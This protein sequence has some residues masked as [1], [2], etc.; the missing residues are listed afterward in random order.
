MKSK[1]LA[2]PDQ[3]NYGNAYAL[4]YKLACEQL[5]RFDDIEQQCRKSGSKYQIIDSK[6]IIATQYLNQSYLITLPDIKISLEDGAEEVPVRERILILH[7]LIAA[8]GTPAANKLITFRELPEGKVYFPTFSQRIIKPLLNHFGK[9]PHILVDLAKK[10]G[11][12]EVDYGDIAVTI[13]AFSRVPITIIL[14]RGDDELPPQGNVVFDANISDY[15][16]TE[17]ITVICE[18]ITWKLIR[19]LKKG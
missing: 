10:L 13:N 8:K 15:L 5:V 11:G 1:H 16:P 18:A 7:Y 14:W 6:G 9:E 12:H 19:Y 4:A 17:D 2:P 3:K